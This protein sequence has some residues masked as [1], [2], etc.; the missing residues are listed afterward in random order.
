MGARQNP[1]SA[2]SRIFRIFRYPFSSL[3]GAGL[4]ALPARASIELSAF[5]PAFLGGGSHNSD[6]SNSQQ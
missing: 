4:L 2:N 1:V 6:L 3:G 5:P